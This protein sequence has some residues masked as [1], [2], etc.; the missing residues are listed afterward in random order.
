MLR[1]PLAIYFLESGVDLLLLE[2]HPLKLLLLDP[3]PLLLLPGL[4]HLLKACAH[5][6]L[7]LERSVQ[8]FGSLVAELVFILR[9]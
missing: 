7:L 9:K 3:P 5:V 2:L 1:L 4:G 8:L 6:H